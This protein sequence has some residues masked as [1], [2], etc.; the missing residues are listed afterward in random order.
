MTSFED[1]G[2]ARSLV[3]TLKFMEFDTPTPIQ[4][5]A[6][7][8]VLQGK[9]IMGLAQTGTGKTG[10]FGLPLI[11][12]LLR[13]PLLAEPHMVR[14][15]ILAPTR[16][17]ATQIATSLRGFAK[18]SP[19]KIGLL[20]GGQ[21]I[22][23]QAQKLA[24]GTDILIA[25]PG[26]LMD[27]MQRK[28]MK[29][30]EVKFLVLDEAD[31]M[32]DLG[33]I[34]DL[35]RI[36]KALPTARQTSMF[37]ATMPKDISALSKDFLTNPVRIE[38]TP[39]GKAADKV[40]QSI[41]MVERPDKAKRLRAVLSQLVKPHAIVFTRT[42]HGADR[43][44]RDL[45]KY[46]YGCA[47]IHGNKSQGQRTRAL[48]HFKAGQIHILV[49]TDVAARGIDI[50]GVTHV[51]NYDLPEVAD[52]YVHRIGRTARAGADGA[53]IAF[54]AQEEQKLLRE[55]EK[56]LKMK[57][58]RINEHH[59]D[60]MADAPGWFR[61]IRPKDTP[62]PQ[63]DS[64]KKSGGDEKR[65]GGRRRSGS[66]A[67]KPGAPKRPGLHP[68]HEAAEGY[69]G[70]KSEAKPAGARTKPRKAFRGRRPNKASQAA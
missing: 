61:D 4:A 35:R 1:M 30:T 27:H 29:L 60:P 59:G 26:R 50:P 8:V 48:D 55:I 56:L 62:A 14:S 53:A 7:P 22:N 51:F 66:S 58:E 15:L 25:T 32:L 24:K 67:A 42:K 33:F 36:A 20:V 49:A 19:L 10:A 5:Q 70:V 47:A 31:Q 28:S 39:P 45:E 40:D 17:L 11:D 3:Q 46:G 63:R 2:L 23:M 34:N 6:I 9:D 54:C 43:L 64:R 21:S 57:I 68:A 44:V 65:G 41:Y 52:V 69:E 12:Q 16:E 38:V 18:K 13:D 37:S